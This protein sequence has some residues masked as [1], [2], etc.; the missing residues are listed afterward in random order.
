MKQLFSILLLLFIVPLA[1]GEDNL[2]KQGEFTKSGIRPWK[3]FSLRT[4]K[5]ATY[6]VDKGVLTLTSTY[7]TGKATRRQLTQTIPELKSETKYKLTFDAKAS[8]QPS[9][10]TVTLSRSKDWKKGHYG[11]LKRFDL[12]PEWKTYTVHFKSKKIDPGNPATLKI[13]FG[14]INGDLSLRHFKLVESDNKKK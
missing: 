11:F 6:A 10:L 2:I 4:T 14:T 7:A 12:T 8:M 13:L 9:L 3:N 1:H 5:K